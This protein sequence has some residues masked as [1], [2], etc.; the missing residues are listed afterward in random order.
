MAFLTH[1]NVAEAKYSKVKKYYFEKDAQVTALQNALANQRLSMSKTSLDDTE[2]TTRFN[3]LDGAINNLSFNI[4]KNWKGVPPW[5]QSVCNKDAHSTGTKEM[6]AIGRAC[7]T[8][9]VVDE[10]FDRFFHPSI[11][12]ALSSQLKVIEK[13]IRK[14]GTIQ[15]SSDEQRDDLTTKLTNWRLTTLEGLQESLVDSQAQECKQHLTMGLVEKLTASLQMNL[16][17]PPPP[18]LESG[19]GMIIEL[20]VGIA[21]FLPIESRDVYVEYFMPNAPINET[22]MK[23]ETNMTPLT[24]PLVGPTCNDMGDQADRLSMTSAPSMNENGE[25]RDAGEPTTTSVN[26][27][28]SARGDSLPGGGQNGAKAGHD[29]KKSFLGGLVA[30]KPTPG[31]GPDTTQAA[32]LGS[33]S[34]SSMSAAQSAKEAQERESIERGERERSSIRFAAFVAVEVRGKGE[35]GAN[36]LVK[37]PCY[38]Y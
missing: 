36:V 14:G 1:A 16:T 23:M 4:R 21:H 30:K 24:N 11:E 5:L 26:Q 31:S 12:P 9:W 17:D 20:A 18:G 15:H 28:T 19:V 35:K 29:K 10:V 32:R 34:N 13:N 25:E 2:Y 27:Q 3:R 8:R 38:G 7:I 37:A 22:F 6:T 33:T